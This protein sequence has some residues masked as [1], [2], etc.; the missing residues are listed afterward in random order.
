M[1]TLRKEV[2]MTVRI[3]G[4]VGAA[5]GCLLVVSGCSFF[6]GTQDEYTYWEP[7]LSP[8][9]TT[10]VNESEGESSL[11]LY[12][13]DLDTNVEQQLTTNEYAD[14]SPDWSPDGSRIAFASSRD[15]NVDLYVLMVATGEVVRVTTHA[16]DDINPHWGEDGLIYFNS[17]R[18]ESWEIFTIDPDTLTLRKV[19]SIEASAT[20]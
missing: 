5:I 14:W 9:E 11:E 20:P 4:I 19:T 10:L 6:G 16:A 7:A 12:T 13:L 15:D 2:A 8:D 17:N 1:G 3:V 18:S